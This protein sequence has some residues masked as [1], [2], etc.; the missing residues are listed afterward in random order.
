MA[1]THYS[2]LAGRIEARTSFP[3]SP[4]DGQQFYHSTYNIMYRYRA[5]DA[6]WWGVELTT[7]TSTSSSTS[8]TTTSTSS[9]TSISTTISTSTSNTTTST[10][11]TTTL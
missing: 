11:T 1:D 5:E 10:S 3:S 4:F 9:S 2:K 8:I 7:T 6:K